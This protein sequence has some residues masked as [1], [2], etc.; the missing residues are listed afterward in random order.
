MPKTSLVGGVLLA[1]F[2]AIAVFSSVLAPYPPLAY[3][4][5]PLES[6][7][8]RHLLGT[9]GTGQDI[10]S[11]LIYGSRVSLPIASGTALCG[12]LVGAGLGLTAGMQR[13]LAD[14]LV[15]RL[16]DVF[17]TIPH[18]PLMLLLAACFPPR[19]LTMMMVLTLVSWPLEARL[20]RSQVLQLR[21]REYLESAWL[22]GGTKYYLARRYILPDL[23]PLLLAQLIVRASW[24]VL[25]ESGL[26]FLGLGDPTAKS[27]GMMLKEALDCPT[28]YFVPAWR[29]WLLPP[30]VCITLL[31]LALTAL[32]HGLEEKYNPML[33]RRK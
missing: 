1:L 17:L 15:M 20:V 18:L 6:P 21:N 25:A 33:N 19:L 11:Q 31:V 23:A 27:W 8:V 26:A 2:S 13:G 16:V 24:A 10:L 29:W 28:I 4:G 3:T 9:N 5:S 12:T 32:G 22:A 7:S 14:R 30:G